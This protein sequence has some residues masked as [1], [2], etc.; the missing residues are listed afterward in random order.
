MSLSSPANIFLYAVLLCR[1]AKLN[2][3]GPG[4]YLAHLVESYGVWPILWGKKAT[5]MRLEMGLPV[6]SHKVRMSHRWERRD[7]SLCAFLMRR[8][9]PC[10]FRP[11]IISFLQAAVCLIPPAYLWHVVQRVRCR[12]DKSFL[13]WMPHVNLL[14][15]FHDPSSF[16]DAARCRKCTMYQHREVAIPFIGRSYLMPR[17]S[18]AGQPPSSS[19]PS[20]LSTCL[21]HTAAPSSMALARRPSG[22]A[23]RALTT[24]TLPRTTNVPTRTAPTSPA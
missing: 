16:H 10:V 12:H 9:T 23:R 20:P 21:Y 6:K 5:G 14:Y 18:I 1:R 4:H 22:W 8:A 17:Q 11:I 15:P 19:L 3:L 2:S 7:F 24:P 13:R